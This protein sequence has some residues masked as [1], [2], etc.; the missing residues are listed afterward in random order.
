MSIA[1]TDLMHGLEDAEN[2]TLI[3][4]DLEWIYCKV[5]LILARVEL[6]TTP[7]QSEP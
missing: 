2:T 1:Y 6:S 5:F 4:L 3:E 7:E